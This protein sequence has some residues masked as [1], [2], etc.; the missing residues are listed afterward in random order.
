MQN[1]SK[2]KAKKLIAYSKK[3]TNDFNEAMRKQFNLDQKIDLGYWRLFFLRDLE[4]LR[5]TEE[6]RKEQG[7]YLPLCFIV[8]GDT[9]KIEVAFD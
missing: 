7:K 3:L 8:N 1:I 9:Q 4:L 5:Q 6:A 2:E